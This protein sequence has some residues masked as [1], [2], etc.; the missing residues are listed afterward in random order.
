MPVRVRCVLGVGGRLTGPPEDNGPIL[1]KIREVFPKDP[2]A[3]AGAGW[4]AGLASPG[5]QIGFWDSLAEIGGETDQE[6]RITFRVEVNSRLDGTIYDRREALTDTHFRKFCQY[7][8]AV[9]H[10]DLKARLEEL[11]RDIGKRYGAEKLIE[12]IWFRE[13][14]FYC[15]NGGDN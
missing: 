6:T 5:W 9:W 8:D 7:R 4:P 12:K 13:W 10:K 3:R 14:Q 1:A 11:N 2:P 15:G